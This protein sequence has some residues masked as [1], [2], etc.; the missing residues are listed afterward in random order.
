MPDALR[1]AWRAVETA[2]ARPFDLILMD[3]RMPEM[4]GV[5]ATRVIRGGEGPNA[6]AYICA[7][8]ADAMPEHQREAQDAGMDAYLSKPISPAE[9]M[10][11]IERARNSGRDGQRGEDAA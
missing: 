11:L 8:S 10:Q 9:L 5:A 3:M 7:L 6:I 4:D 1:A 2:G